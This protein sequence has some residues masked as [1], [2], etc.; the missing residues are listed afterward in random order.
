LADLSA[1]RSRKIRRFSF[2]DYQAKRQREGVTFTGFVPTTAELTPD[3]SGNYN[4]AAIR[5]AYATDESVR[6]GTEPSTFQLRE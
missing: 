2:L 1:V 4:L 6:T 3:G 5:S